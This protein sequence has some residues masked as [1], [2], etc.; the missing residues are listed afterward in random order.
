MTRR[1]VI[2]GAGSVSPLGIG[3]KETCT[4]LA[5]AR[6]GVDFVTLFDTLAVPVNIAAEVSNWR[7]TLLPK[8]N[9][10]AIPRQSQ[11]AVYAAQE[12]AKQAGL[13]DFDLPP[14][15]LGVYLGCGEVFPDLK[16]LAVQ[17]AASMVN[18]HFNLH[19]FIS[20]TPR[21]M[22]TYEPSDAAMRLAAE[23][24]A[25]GLVAN[26]VS[27]CVSSSQAIGRAADAIAYDDADVM[28]AGGAHTLLNAFAAS[29]FFSLG[30]LSTRTDSPKEAMRPF[31]ANRDG[32]VMGEGGAIFVLE[33]Y[34][35]ARRRGADILVEITGY[36]EAQDA[37]RITDP[38]PEGRGAISAMS[39]SLKSAK[40]A[41]SEIS[42]ISAHGTGTVM[43]DRMETHAVKTV[44]GD[45]DSAPPASSIKS[46]IGHLTTAGGALEVLA[47]IM[48][49]REGVL[50][51][52]INYETPDP[53]CDLD[54]I[55]NEAR[56]VKCTHAISNSFG[57]GGQN[58]ALVLSRA[59]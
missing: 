3:A 28:F 57:F 12:A 39:R 8:T 37:Y 29:G 56:E 26:C 2:T 51:P 33:E 6:S 42:Y 52:T 22:S 13:G 23:F 10:Q 54:Y 15:R 53:D 11:F 24:N 16:D 25:Q 30:A 1:V 41:P 47:C 19:E 50:P 32:F 20:H 17:T 21:S 5:E 45:G 48:A 59:S 44:F 7:D 27:A 49:V 38:H 36:G 46:M 9:G 31:D 58:T 4:G 55:P 40:L 43:N 18:E 34:E 14:N 35:H